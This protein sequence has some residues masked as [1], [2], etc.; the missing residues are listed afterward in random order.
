MVE[1]QATR[2]KVK[3]HW[4]PECCNDSIMGSIDRPDCPTCI[5]FDVSS[6]RY[7]GVQVISTLASSTLHAGLSGNA[8]GDGDC[9]GRG[10][11]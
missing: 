8:E 1:M 10:F 7:L 4:Q 3:C 6:I 11:R 2:V 9:L 5:D